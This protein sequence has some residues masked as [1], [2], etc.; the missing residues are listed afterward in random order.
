MVSVVDTR[1][2]DVQAVVIHE[3][4]IVRR[5]LQETV[6]GVET[7]FYLVYPDLSV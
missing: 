2:R 3:L 4:R 7:L 5:L 1:R 6:V